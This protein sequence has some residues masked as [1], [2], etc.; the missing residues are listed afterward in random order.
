MGRS[1]IEELRKVGG[2]PWVI[3]LVPDDPDTLREIFGRLAG[4]FLTGGVDVD[5]TRYGEEQSPLCGTTDPDRASSRYAPSGEATSSPPMTPVPVTRT[6]ASPDTLA[7]RVAEIGR[8]VNGV[9]L[10]RGLK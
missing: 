6:S 7:S 3:P 4:V 2:V 1:Y 8:I 9:P 5:P 10:L